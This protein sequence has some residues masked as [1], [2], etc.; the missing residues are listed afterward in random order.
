MARH[1]VD[2]GDVQLELS[3]LR[4]GS[5]GAALNQRFECS[6]SGPVFYFLGFN[7]FRDRK[8]RK[9]PGARHS[10]NLVPLGLKEPRA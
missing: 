5:L 3:G 8:E 4:I 9:L 2:D 7:I 1:P 10:S 6:D